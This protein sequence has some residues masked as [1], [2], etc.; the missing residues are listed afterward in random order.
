MTVGTEPVSTLPEGA[1]GGAWLIQNLG[2]EAIY[3][4][5]TAS[6]A[7]VGNGVRIGVNQAVGINLGTNPN[8]TIYASTESATSSVR[9]L[10]F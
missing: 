8:A 5:R 3:V 10:R 2:P 4:A 7:T 9:T 1:E 6:Q